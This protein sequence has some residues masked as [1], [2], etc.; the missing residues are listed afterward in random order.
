MSEQVL[1]SSIIVNRDTRQRRELTDI[2]ELAASIA[3]IGQ[4][5]PIIIRADNTLVAGERRL[6]ACT[7]LGY[8]HIKAE[9]WESLTPIE[10]ERIE[11]AEN[12]ERVDLTWQDRAAAI[13]R[14]R[15]LRADI[16]LADLAVELNISYRNLLRYL[17]VQEQIVSGNA[18]V[19]KA[20]SFTTASNITARA[21]TRKQEAELEA[22]SASILGSVPTEP[23]VACEPVPKPNTPI[24]LADF[25]EFAATYSGPRFNF[26]HCDFPYGI[27]ADKHHQGAA[28]Y[29]RGYA[30]TPD[31]YWQL[32]ATLGDNMQR[33]VADSAHMIFWYSLDFHHETILALTQMGWRVNPFPLI[34]FKNDNTGILPDPKRGPRRVYETAFFCS[35][36]DRVVV[37]AVANCFPA[38]A[39]KSVHMSE[40]NLQMLTHF[41]RMTVDDNTIMLDPTCG[42]GNA[43]LAASALGAK[44]LTGL[45]RDPAIHAAAS[46]HFLDMTTGSL[47]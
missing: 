44:S 27:N 9:R 3:A 20:E 42:S 28:K 7:S 39:T 1:I 6:T 25:N 13:S 16:T 4:I 43:L 12:L 11:L 31:V 46:A 41:F 29:F 34:W 21:G 18:L 40:K 5:S 33:L 47:L 15:E 19:A 38:P 37:Q 26:I 45:E 30:D 22:I 8:T 14:Y 23:T 2:T 35:R 36:G 32:V 24:T 17:D 10:A